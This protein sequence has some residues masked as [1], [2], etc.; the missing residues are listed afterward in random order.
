ML[1]M[2][3]NKMS[4]RFW[5]RRSRTR[6]G[7]TAVAAITMKPPPKERFA[8]HA[9]RKMSQAPGGVLGPT[10]SPA[11]HRSS[12]TG[13]MSCGTCTERR[14]VIGD[15][16]DLP[17]VAEAGVVVRP[18]R[19]MTTRMR[20]G[21]VVHQWRCL[22]CF[23]EDALTDAFSHFLAGRRCGLRALGRSSSG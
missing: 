7:A 22:R 5:S 17:C 18:H 8:T 20:A 3:K 21:K 1:T 10:A 4:Q 11:T 16:A 23:A 6:R 13:K 19:Y 15:F 9:E 2:L 14:W 12:V